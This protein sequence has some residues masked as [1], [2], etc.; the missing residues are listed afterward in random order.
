MK[1]NEIREIARQ[2]NLKIGKSTKS[3]LVRSIQLAEGY[4]Q[5]F[6]SNFSAE[7]GQHTCAWRTDCG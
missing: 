6:D 4:Q 7:C 1:L 2:H 3:E 5:C